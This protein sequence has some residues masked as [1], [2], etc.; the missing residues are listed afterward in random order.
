MLFSFFFILNKIELH[1]FVPLSNIVG[2]RYNR[3]DRRLED[4]M[5]GE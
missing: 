2:S 1:D 5:I 4:K 3:V